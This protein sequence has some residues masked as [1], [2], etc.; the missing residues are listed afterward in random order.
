MHLPSDENKLEYFDYD[1]RAPGHGSFEVQVRGKNIEVIDMDDKI[2]L[3]VADQNF[4]NEITLVFTHK[5]FDTFASRCMN[6]V[7]YK[8]CEI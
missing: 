8:E 7:Y 2:Y 4:K 3:T 6:V 5:E 1:L